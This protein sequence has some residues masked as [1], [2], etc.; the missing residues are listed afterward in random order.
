MEAVRLADMGLSA[1][2]IVHRLQELAGRVEASFVIDSLEYL[3]KGGRCSALAALGANLLNLKPC[4]EVVDGKRKVGQK[5]P[6]I[7]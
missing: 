3:R 4:I 6:R 1:E 5:I 7:V 2:D